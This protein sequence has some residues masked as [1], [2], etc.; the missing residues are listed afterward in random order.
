VTYQHPLAWLTRPEGLA[1]LRAP[2]AIIWHFRQ[3]R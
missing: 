3:A 1:L 2:A